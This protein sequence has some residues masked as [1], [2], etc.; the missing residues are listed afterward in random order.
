MIFQSICGKRLHRVAGERRAAARPAPRRWW[1]AGWSRRRS[2]TRR[3]RPGTVDRDDLAIEATR[4]GGRGGGQP[5]R[6][7]RELVEL[8]AAESPLRRDQLGRDAL[9]DQA[10]GVTA[11]RLPGPNGVLPERALPIGTRL[12]D[13]TP[14]AITMSYAPADDPLRREVRRLLAR[15]A[16]PVDRGG[17]HRLG[18]ARREHALPADV[19]RLLADLTDAA[20]DDVLDPAPGR[21]RCAAPVPSARRRAVRPG[22]RRTA[23]PPACPCRTPYGRRRR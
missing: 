13:S 20:G 15:A 16:L 4:G 19:Q 7:G 6:S 11:G 17:R 22:G 23:L 1:R 21:G 2:N 18:P 10:V 14:P 5:V 9:A 12:I 8:L 3:R